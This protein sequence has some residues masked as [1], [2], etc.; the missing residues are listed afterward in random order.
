MISTNKTSSQLSQLAS[1]ILNKFWEAELPSFASRITLN[2]KPKGFSVEISDFSGIYASPFQLQYDFKSSGKFIL[3]VDLPFMHILAQ[4][5]ALLAALVYQAKY[6]STYS[7]PERVKKVKQTAFVPREWVDTGDLSSKINALINNPTAQLVPINTANTGVG[8]GFG[9]KDKQ[10]GA[11]AP[12]VNPTTGEIIVPQL[13]I[14]KDNYLEPEWFGMFDEMVQDGVHVR[15]SG[16]PGTGKTTAAKILAT[17][18]GVKLFSMNCDGRIGRA[19]LEGTREMD[20]GST[21][22]KWSGFARAV[23]EGH[24]ACLNELNMAE[25]DAIIILNSMVEEPFSMVVDGEEVPVHKN[26]RLFVTYNPGF[27]G[28]KSLPDSLE[29]RLFH[30]P[31][32]HPDSRT[33]QLILKTKGFSDKICLRLSML[34]ELVWADSVAKKIKFELGLRHL[35]FAGKLLTKEY[36]WTQATKFGVLVNIK[37]P[38]DMAIIR[39]HVEKLRIGR[40]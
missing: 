6:L 40:I 34:A 27:A 36:S 4:N 7:D 19:H 22:F 18:K 8:W 33:T 3:Y 26:F 35:I 24:W 39:S 5:E 23:K 2:P 12:T 1:T 10:V 30:I 37:T 20:K 25:P 29:D 13:V 17:R 14:P 38:N 32:D 21:K 31:V 15:F 28:T 11:N 9:D 16:P